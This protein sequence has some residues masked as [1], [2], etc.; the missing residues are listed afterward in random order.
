MIF[1][2]KSYIF[3]CRVSVVYELKENDFQS[4]I[5]YC[6]WFQ[7]FLSDGGEDILDV[8]LFSD[9]AWFYLSR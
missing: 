9:E 8:T 6:K 3:S 5:N 2:E 1:N 7:N 4:R